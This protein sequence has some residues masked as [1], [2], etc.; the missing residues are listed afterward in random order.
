M[1]KKVKKGF[2][3][4]ELLI[5]VS[6]IGILSVALVPSITDAP[7]RARDAAR[8]TMVNSVVAAVESF[9]LDKGRYP[10]GVFCVDGAAGTA[11]DKEILV[12]LIGGGAP[13]S[14][15]AVTGT[16]TPATVAG[17]CTITNTNTYVTYYAVGTSG[18]TVSIPMETGK[19]T[20][21]C[22]DTNCTVDTTDPISNPDF[23]VVR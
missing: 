14:S 16:A 4:I 17:K 7:K 11:T 10:L 15:A 13:K 9:N 20:H 6:I 22:T 12:G 8:K 5:V 3:L 2:T 18:Y 1:I 23:A 21:I 19:G